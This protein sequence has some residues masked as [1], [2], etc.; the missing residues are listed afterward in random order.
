MFTIDRASIVRAFCDECVW[1]YC[2]RKHFADL[3]EGNDGRR[4]LLAE[5]AG[6]FFH[7]LNLVLIDYLLLQQC[8]LT[9]PASSGKNKD[10][11][12]TN[13]IVALD[14]TP[15]TAQVLASANADIMSFR[16]KIDD[17]RRKLVAHLDLRA[18]LQTLDLG[19]FSPDDETKFWAALQTFVD[20]A[21]DEA[22]GGPF[23]FRVAMPAGDVSSLIHALKDAV[24]YEDIHGQDGAFLLSRHGQRRFDDA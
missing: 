3:F 20:A 10:N 23:D 16:A 19:S 12:T 9:D 7:D 18:R 24:D 14:W 1:L 22:I 8:K 4:R 5:V 15:T 2:L 11:L 6:T 13:Y 21:H 17:A